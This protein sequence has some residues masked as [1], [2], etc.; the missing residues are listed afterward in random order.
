MLSR[1]VTGT[2]LLALALA[3]AQ[4]GRQVH[5]R[6]CQGPWR[7]DLVE[8]VVPYSECWTEIVIAHLAMPNTTDPIA[9]WDTS[10]VTDMSYTFKHGKRPDTYPWHGTTAAT[11]AFDANLAAW[12]TRRVGDM[13]LMFEGARAFAD[14]NGGLAGWDTSKVSSMYFMFS[15]A[16]SFS[17]DLNKWD[18]SNVVTMAFMFAHA[19][20]FNGNITGF[21]TRKVDSMQGMFLDT[22][23][24]NGFI[25][26]WQTSAVRGMSKMFSGVRAFDQDLGA[27]DVRR[28]SSAGFEDMFSGHSNSCARNRQ[29]LYPGCCNRFRIYSGWKNQTVGFAEA[30]NPFRPG[31]RSCDQKGNLTNHTCLANWAEAEDC[32]VATTSQ[33]TTMPSTTRG[34]R[35][36]GEGGTGRDSP[37]QTATPTTSRTTTTTATSTATTTQTTTATRSATS[38]AT[39]TPSSSSTTPTTTAALSIDDNTIGDVVD[40]WESAASGSGNNTDDNGIGSWNVSAVKTMDSLFLD[41]PKFNATISHWQVDQVT[42]MVGMFANATSFNSDVSKW[43]VAQVTAMQGMFAGASSFNSDISQWNVAR[44]RGKEPQNQNRVWP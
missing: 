26:P 42:S 40:R 39:T 9:N 22:G 27:W 38:T 4:D 23:A 34:S 15:G 5:G 36:Q 14:Q 41:K 37:S 1:R 17:T 12:D 3:A 28:I 43:N 13:G 30:A 24:F 20:K 31:Y 18:T 10:Y 16:S 6:S 11:A 29:G 8:D 25:S 2:R 33:T 21:D 7:Q 32:D 19:A 35:L 44:V